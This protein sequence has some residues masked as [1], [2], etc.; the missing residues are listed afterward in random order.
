MEGEGFGAFAEGGV[1]FLRLHSTRLILAVR[2]DAPFYELKSN[3][4][5]AWDAATGTTVMQEPERR[6]YHVPVTVAATYA[7]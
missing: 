4:G 6:E 7:W 1:E 3:P 2:V 5:Y